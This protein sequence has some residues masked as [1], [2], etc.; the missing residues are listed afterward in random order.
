MLRFM[1]HGLRLGAVRRFRAKDSRVRK[2]RAYISG[3]GFE[4]A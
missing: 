1:G 4:A 3:I 2:F